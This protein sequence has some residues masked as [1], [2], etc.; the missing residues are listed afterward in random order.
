MLQVGPTRVNHTKQ[1]KIFDWK[2]ERI[3]VLFDVLATETQKDKDFKKIQESH[4]TD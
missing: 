4:F 2:K 3:C 1:P